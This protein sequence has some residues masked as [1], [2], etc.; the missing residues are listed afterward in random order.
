MTY[1][2]LICK[3]AILTNADRR[4]DF[5]AE[6]NFE[7]VFDIKMSRGSGG[8][9]GANNIPLGSRSQ[10]GSL[11]AAASSLGGISL[12]NPSYLGGDEPQSSGRRSK[13]GPPVD[14]KP[15]MVFSMMSILFIL[16]L[17]SITSIFVRFN[18]DYVYRFLLDSILSMS[19]DFC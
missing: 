14:G 17:L 1:F 9:S 8:M 18:A 10:G 4:S 19:V 3:H 13:F 2:D 15:L 6:I 11:A 12:L 7:F 16:S 5:T